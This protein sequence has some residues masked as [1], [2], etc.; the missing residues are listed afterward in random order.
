MP[1]AIRY[2]QAVYGSFPFWDKGYAILASSPGCR[3]EWLAD[4]R[5]ACQRYGE[6]PPGAAE[7]GGLMALRLESGPWAIIRPCPQGAD[8]RGRPGALAFH[9]VF[10]SGTD[11][12]KAGAFPFAFAEIFCKDWTADTVLEAGSITLGEAAPALPS[13]PADPRASRIA[14]ALVR[15]RRVAIEAPGPIDEL[16]RQVWLALPLRR[17][18]KLSLATWVFANGNQFDFAA[19]PRLSGITLDRTYVDPETMRPL[20]EAKGESREVHRV[21]EKPVLYP[22]PQGGRGQSLKP[23]KLQAPPSVWGRLRVAGL[24]ET[25]VR[26][27]ELRSRPLVLGLAGLGV[28]ALALSIFLLIWRSREEPAPIAPKVVQSL[29]APPA[30]PTEPT[31]VRREQVVEGLLSVAERFGTLREALAAPNPGPEVIMMRL[32][33]RLTYSGPLLTQAELSRLESSPDPDHARVLAWHAHILHFR[34]GR[35]LPSDFG[36][37]PLDWQV[38]T[39]AWSFYLDPTGRPAE[40]IPQFLFDALSL[41]VSSRPSPLADAYPVLG[42]Y[43]RFLRRLPAR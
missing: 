36:R 28:A 8:D 25:L 41:P 1:V 10:L 21:D 2:E 6:R 19:L 43:A 12:R 11:Y 27:T 26:S 20:L 4:L 14:N 35:S 22:S 9:A 24:G 16:A 18:R 17:R 40:E 37:G 15:G 42:E 31:P 3:E 7:A 34:P 33:E 5:A 32:R 39:L 13:P 23:D 38:R 30:R 29:D